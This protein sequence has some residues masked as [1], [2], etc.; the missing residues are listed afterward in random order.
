MGVRCR[1]KRF[2]SHRCL[3][4]NFLEPK[5]NHKSLDLISMISYFRQG[6]RIV[7]IS[8]SIRNIYTHDLD[9]NPNLT[10]QLCNIDAY[11]CHLFGWFALPQRFW[12]QTNTRQAHRFQPI[13]ER[14]ERH[15][16]QVRCGTTA[17]GTVGAR[18]CRSASL[19]GEALLLRTAARGRAPHRAPAHDA[20]DVGARSRSML[21][22]WIWSAGSG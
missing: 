12:K 9:R 11:V 8:A 4:E 6:W 7:G 10:S 3:N 22:R 18:M 19:R 1:S 2:L 5:P 16:A 20:K 17:R 13:W 15:S 14:S 21:G